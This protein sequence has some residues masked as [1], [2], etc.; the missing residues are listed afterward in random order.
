MLLSGRSRAIPRSSSIVI[1]PQIKL[2]NF[3]G[4]NLGD[5]LREFFDGISKEEFAKDAPHLDCI[6][7]HKNR[8]K[9]SRIVYVQNTA[10][11]HHVE[12]HMSLL[13]P[14]SSS[15]H[16]FGGLENVRLVLFSDDRGHDVAEPKSI[17]PRL[18][19]LATAAA[20]SPDEGSFSIVM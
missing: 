13:F 15:A 16:D 20:G 8:L 19:E 1:N 3:V 17:V 11:A 9:N 12:R 14:K 6:V 7:E 18:V 2:S 4:N 5:Y 10:D